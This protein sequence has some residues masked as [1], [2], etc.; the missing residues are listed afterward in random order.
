MKEL[1]LLL[2]SKHKNNSASN[3]SSTGLLSPETHSVAKEVVM[4]HSGKDAPVPVFLKLFVTSNSK[5]SFSNFSVAFLCVVFSQTQILHDLQIVSFCF[6][7]RLTLR[8]NFFRDKLVKKQYSL[9]FI[10]SVDSVLRR[11]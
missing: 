6:D 5:L 8:P 1:I 9:S 3:T 10:G 11:V 4:Q 7:L 2:L